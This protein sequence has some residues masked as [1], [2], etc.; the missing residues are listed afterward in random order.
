MHMAKASLS[1]Q[2]STATA[3]TYGFLFQVL[4]N[5]LQLHDDLFET[6]P[7]LRILVPA[8]LQ[9]PVIERVC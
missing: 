8:I 5:D 6:W 7:L 1:L 9:K 4:L 3:V 2:D